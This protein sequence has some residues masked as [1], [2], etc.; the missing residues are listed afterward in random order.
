MRPR[1][2]ARAGWGFSSRL[3]L[4]ADATCGLGV[5]RARVAGFFIDFFLRG[6]ALAARVLLV[7]CFL[8]VSFLFGSFSFLSSAVPVLA[9]PRRNGSARQC[10]AR[11]CNRTSRSMVCL[12][13]W[14]RRVAPL[15]GARFH[16]GGGDGWTNGYGGGGGGGGGRGRRAKGEGLVD[17]RPC[18]ASR[19]MDGREVRVGRCR[20]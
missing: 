9:C 13:G 6:L 18:V 20:C 2:R 16:W 10:N 17:T 7:F 1:G 15:C 14:A 5:V 19:D 11:Q 3:H 8:G 12:G 4:T